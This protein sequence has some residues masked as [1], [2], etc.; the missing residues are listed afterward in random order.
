MRTLVSR[1][2]LLAVGAMPS[3]AA[4]GSPNQLVGWSFVD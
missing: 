3:Q 1:V 2:L 4:I